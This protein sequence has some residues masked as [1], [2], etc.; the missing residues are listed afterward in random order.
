MIQYV[1]ASFRH[2]ADKVRSR[3]ADESLL[4]E[5]YSEHITSPTLISFDGSDMR[6]SMMKNKE[7]L[8]AIQEAIPNVSIVESASCRVLLRMAKDNEAKWKLGAEQQ[9]FADEQTSR[10][11]GLAMELAGHLRKHKRSE[12]AQWL[13]DA[14]FMQSKKETPS[15][16]RSPTTSQWTY[17]Y[18]EQAQASQSIEHDHGCVLLR[19]CL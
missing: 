11:R 16:T 3:C 14:G 6:G 9:R 13:I 10:I 19:V 8:I 2:M 1:Q 7:F 5:L 17:G 4:Y 15:E 18:D 12:P